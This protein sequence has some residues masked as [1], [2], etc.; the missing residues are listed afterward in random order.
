MH[1]LMKS[2]KA[3]W[4][5]CVETET[6]LNRITTQQWKWETEAAYQFG[7]STVC[8]HFGMLLSSRPPDS[9]PLFRWIHINTSQNY[10]KF[11]MYWSWWIWVHTT[12]RN[13]KYKSDFYFCSVKRFRCS[14]LR[15]LKIC[16]K[17]CLVL[18]GKWQ[19]N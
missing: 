1:L 6:F 2:F 12:C 17:I 9:L 4:V 13:L 14:L 15:V 11:W 16:L 19:F 5:L 8:P 18:R 3:L 7:I 10:F